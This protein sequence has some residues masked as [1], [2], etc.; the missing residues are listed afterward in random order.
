VFARPTGLG[1]IS[2]GAMRLSWIRA[3]CVVASPRL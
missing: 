1:V 2:A 3:Y